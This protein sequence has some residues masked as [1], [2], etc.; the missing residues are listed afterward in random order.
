MHSLRH[1]YA[2]PFRLPGHLFAGEEFDERHA[3]LCRR[4]AGIEQCDFHRR[5]R[6]SSLE[7][8]PFH[9]MCFAV[10]VFEVQSVVVAVTEEVKDTGLPPLLGGAREF[11]LQLIERWRQDSAQPDRQLRAANDL[12]EMHQFLAEIQRAAEVDGVRAQHQNIQILRHQCRPF[13][14]FMDLHFALQSSLRVA[15]ATAIVA[16]GSV[17]FLGARIFGSQSLKLSDRTSVAGPSYGGAIASGCRHG[18]GWTF[19]VGMPFFQSCRLQEERT[20]R[21]GKFLSFAILVLVTGAFGVLFFEVTST[22]LLPLFLAMVSVVM[23]RPVQIRCVRLLGGRNRVAAVI[24]TTLVLLVV[25]VPSI[26][27]ILLACSEAAKLVRSLDDGEFRDQ[28]HRARLSLG[29][30]YPYVGQLRFAERSFERL[31]ADAREGAV[32]SGNRDA[33]QRLHEELQRLQVTLNKD[34]S[35]PGPADA[36]LMLDALTKAQQE[37]PGTLAY[38]LAMETAARRFHAYRVEFLGGAPRAVLKNIANPTSEDVTDWTSRIFAVT[39]DW[40]S[41]FGGRAGLTPVTIIEFV[42]LLQGSRGRQ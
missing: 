42:K 27:V 11:A 23:F 7:F 4:P 17:E 24:T 13:A 39:P 37:T 12:L 15:D 32:A 31:L 18:L 22:L 8:V 2:Q 3:S 35:L 38:Q 26:V 5:L 41:A 28:L 40:I 21:V 36:K 25:V 19:V 33:L 10:L 16:N 20:N 30:D 14:P 9:A 34:V 6:Q 1:Q 29:L